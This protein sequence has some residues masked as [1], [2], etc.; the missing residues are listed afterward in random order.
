MIKAV[1]IDI[2]N[3]ILDFDAYVKQTMEDGFDKFQIGKYSDDMF[4]VFTN[5]NNGLWQQIEEGT[6][7]FE[8]LQKV[9]WNKIF[10][11]LG[12]SFDGPTFEKYFR[13]CLNESAI[14]E[15]GALE[16]IKWLSKRYILCTASNGPHNQQVHRIELGGFKPYFTQIFTS[17][18]LGISKPSELFFEKCRAILSENQLIPIEYNEILMI[19]DSLTSDISGS[20]SLGMKT[21][22]YNK[23]KKDIPKGLEPDYIV[24]H[25]IDICELKL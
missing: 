18:R 6:I 16:L 9:R 3:T 25:L 20:K 22:L 23:K 4:F 1:L 24:D 19:G 14:P 2:D 11:E 17:G 13:A 5:I 15:P 8:D 12:F 7:T 10:A 21:C